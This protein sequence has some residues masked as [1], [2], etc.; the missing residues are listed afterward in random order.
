M[1]MKN[2]CHMCILVF[3]VIMRTRRRV[4]HLENRWER[5]A[6][7]LEPVYISQIACTG[8]CPNCH[9]DIR[10]KMWQG[11]YYCPH[12]AYFLKLSR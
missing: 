12:C 9:A 8:N 11:A 2:I 6:P 3:L 1:L 7:A 5:F 10:K 4:R